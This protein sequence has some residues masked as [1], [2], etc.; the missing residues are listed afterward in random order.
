VID[1]LVRRNSAAAPPD[2]AAARPT[3]Q[4]AVLTCMDA[5]IDPVALFGVRPGEV[6]VLRNAGAVVT[7]DVERSLAISQR[8]LG[9]TQVMVVAHTR[10]GMATFT[11]DE[12]ATEVAAEAGSRPQWPVHTFGD[13]AQNVHDGLARLRQS[14]FLRPGAVV[15]GYVYDV[16]TGELSPIG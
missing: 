12:F 13:P 10:C 16:D 1:E 15:A 3:L 5:R 14:Q 4:V 6:H 8:K 7:D 2:Q 9:T 11:D